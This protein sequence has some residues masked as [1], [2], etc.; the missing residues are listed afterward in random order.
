MK[1]FIDTS[2]WLALEIKN[3]IN[4]SSAKKFAQ[5]LIKKRALLFTN[6]HVLSETYTRL[7]YDINL[8]TATKFQETIKKAV[9]KNLR[10]L[11]L[12]TMEFDKVFEELKRY[13]DKKFSFTDGSIV[14]HYK[15]YRLDS[16]FTFDHSFKEAN[17][18]TNL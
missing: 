10:V 5:E 17:L 11:E 7:I 16:I 9:S 18:P 14:F 4:H 8:K 13:K 1:V 3:D 6:N 15:K 2:A 12:L